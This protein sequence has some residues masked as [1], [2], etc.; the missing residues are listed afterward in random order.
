MSMLKIENTFYK[1]RNTQFVYSIFHKNF[2]FMFE[3]LKSIDYGMF[4]EFFMSNNEIYMNSQ[5]S[6]I[7]CNINR[8]EC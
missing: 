4:V 7:S 1:N 8:S 2:K 3:V 6:K 5:V